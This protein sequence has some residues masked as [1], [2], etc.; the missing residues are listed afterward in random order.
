MPDPLQ[1]SA[2]APQ[3]VAPP[4][5]QPTE[6][7]P[8]SVVFKWKGQ[9][10]E[11]PADA[12]SVL[13]ERLGYEKPEA[14]LNMLQMGKD[15]DVLYRQARDY[16]ERAQQA[17]A[18][19]PPVEQRWQQH[20]EREAYRQPQAPPPQNGDIDPLALL[21]DVARRTMAF[22]Q[23]VQGQ[24]QQRQ[25]QVQQQNEMLVDKAIE[26]YSKW[27]AQKKEEGFP[28]YKIPP[29]EQLFSEARRYGM[30]RP[31]ADLSGVYTNLHKMHF[32]DDYAQMAVNRQMARL[33]DPKARVAVPT[34][35]AATPPPRQ[36]ANPLDGMTL[37]DL[38]PEGKY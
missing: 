26:D 13:A 22:E 23:Y 9:E 21:Q 33:R 30:L 31:D 28:D 35:P 7:E 10:V 2:E 15:A 20:V 38:L 29:L 6:V 37:K 5:E 18:Q 24:E 14:V 1:A 3:E 36:P 19:P 17:P 11:L 32:V 8:S 12:V 27:A 25:W 4:D 34:G 16:Y